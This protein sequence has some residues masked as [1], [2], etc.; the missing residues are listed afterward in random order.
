MMS[1]RKQGAKAEVL[2]AEQDT[3]VESRERGVGY[4]GGG[5]RERRTMNG[6][7]TPE[8]GSGVTATAAVT[9]R[10]RDDITPPVSTA[11]S[12]GQRR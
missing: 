6:E 9:R 11:N 8:A 3:V 7:G 4:G 10:R 1:A 5:V 2:A 12:L